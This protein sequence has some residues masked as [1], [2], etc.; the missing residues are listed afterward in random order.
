MFVMMLQVASAEPC[1]GGTAHAVSRVGHQDNPRALA[2]MTSTELSAAYPQVDGSSAQPGNKRTSSEMFPSGGRFWA[3]MSITVCTVAV[4]G[5]RACVSHP[6][7]TLT[8]A[9]KSRHPY[10]TRRSLLHLEHGVPAHRRPMHALASHLGQSP[11]SRAFEED[12]EE[13]CRITGAAH[14]SRRRSD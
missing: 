2:R 11:H 4:H 1:A 10:D 9:P 5:M 8:G 12:T 7:V 14:G 6:S 13:H 3:T